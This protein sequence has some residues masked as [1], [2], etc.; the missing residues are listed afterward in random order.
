RCGPSTIWRTLKASR[1][2]PMISRLRGR[3][4]RRLQ[5]RTRRWRTTSSRCC[6][7]GGTSRWPPAPRTCGP[8]DRPASPSGRSTRA[9][10]STQRRRTYW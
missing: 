5:R 10:G 9:A 7:C 2:P 1:G 6:S 4:S 3:P 8:R